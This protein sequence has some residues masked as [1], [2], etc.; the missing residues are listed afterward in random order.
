MFLPN[1]PL[2]FY[3]KDRDKVV[4]ES[5]F[6]HSL[7]VACIAEEVF[8]Q[9]IKVLSYKNNLNI[10]VD[11][12]KL[13]LTSSIL[14]DV[15]KASEHYYERL[16]SGDAFEIS[17][18]GHHIV[19]G[20]LLYVT[21][22]YAPSDEYRKLLRLAAKVV[23][24]HHQAFKS[25]IYDNIYGGSIEKI[26]KACEK[27]RVDWIKK[28]IDE[29]SKRMYLDSEV[30]KLL[31]NTLQNLDKRRI[32]QSSTI[33]DIHRINFE[34]LVELKLFR[35]ATGIII[36]SDYIVANFNRDEKSSLAQLFMK[37]LKL[38]NESLRKIL[39][40]CLNKA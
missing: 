1:E 34:N 22:L 7:G 3:K 39:D 21:S 6:C 38:S 31:L 37:E 26:I 28:L 10:N 33:N 29:A 30:A 19:S 11:P 13:L 35:V 15:G 14:H 17:F 12:V 18:G 8:S 40:N 4:Q 23:A 5:L 16:K 24:S 9:R 2:S 36:I 20:I 32:C 25:G 27:L